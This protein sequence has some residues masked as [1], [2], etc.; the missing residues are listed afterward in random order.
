MNVPRFVMSKSRGPI[1]AAVA[2]LALLVTG[3]LLAQ[4][5]K[6]AAPSPGDKKNEVRLPDDPKLLKLHEEFVTKAEKLAKDYEKDEKV[7]KAVACYEEILRLVPNYPKAVAALTKIRQREA[8]AD[9]KIFEVQADKGWQDSGVTLI[10]GKPVSIRAS[11]KWIFRMEHE[12]GPDGIPI[13]EDLREF[14][15]GSLLGLVVDGDPKDA[16][17]FLVGS[18]TEF[19]SEV[20]GKLLLRMYDGKMEDNAGKMKVE[21]V[22]TFE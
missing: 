8:T 6:G 18:G 22:G 5:P 14:N 11:G 7:E 12:L 2:L 16:K 21:I 20:S 17:P 4:R 13:P 10:Q 1:S 15:L 19:V 9:K 3:A